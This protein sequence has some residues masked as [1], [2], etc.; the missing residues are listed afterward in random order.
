M[1]LRVMLCAV[2]LAASGSSAFAAFDDYKP[3][4][5]KDVFAIDKNACDALGEK[6]VVV[7]VL[8]QVFRVPAVWSGEI[9]P[10]DP[11]TQNIISAYGKSLHQPTWG[12]L[13]K[14][15]IRVS[16][17]G[18]DYWLAIQSTIVEAFKSEVHKGGAVELC[19]AFYGCWPKHP[20]ASVNEFQ[21]Q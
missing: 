2:A 10:I 9:R 1:K 4:S 8:R 21:A 18:V 15:E 14:Q 6:E 13:F 5:L 11:R 16:D 17:G 19:V 3:S 12:D 7:D 20:V